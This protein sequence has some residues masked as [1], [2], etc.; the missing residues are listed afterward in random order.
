MSAHNLGPPARILAVAD[1]F[2]A[3]VSDRPYRAGMPI[4]QALAI[5]RS[6]AGSKL[7]PECAEQLV[8]LAPS[9]AP[10]RVAANQAIQPGSTVPAS[11]SR[12]LVPA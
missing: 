9:L 10:A 3:L 12:T 4:E 6:D 2:D 5:I 11:P 8:E 1:V 7:C